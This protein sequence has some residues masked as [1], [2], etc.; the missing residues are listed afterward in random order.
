MPVARRAVGMRE[1]TKST[2]V[3][4]IDIVRQG[5]WKLARKMH[6]EGR[7]PQED[8]LFYLP[9]WEIDELFKN[10]NPLFIWKAKHRKKLFE[11]I[12]KWKFDEVVKGYN[13]KPKEV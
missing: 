11:K 7:I 13:F 8:L 6:E 12:D 4:S 3:Y 10:R 1:S 5:L 9:V 2:I